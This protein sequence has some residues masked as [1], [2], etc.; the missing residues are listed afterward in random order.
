MRHFTLAI[1]SFAFLVQSCQNE[2]TK[3]CTETKS[4]SAIL[5]EFPDT[6]KV[7]T[8]YNLGI[9]YV[10]ENSCGQF[11]HFD[12]NYSEKTYNIKLI[13]KYEGCSCKIEL[14]EKTIDYE[15]DVDFPGSYEFR[16]WL[17]DGDYDSR[18]LSVVE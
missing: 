1:L 15:I 6:L 8:K 2:G 3:P 7:G 11:D 9:S 12:V 4:A 5:G 16:F 13:T 18:L 14:E 17:A 10:I